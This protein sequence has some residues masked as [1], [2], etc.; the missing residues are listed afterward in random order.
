MKIS[1]HRKRTFRA[2]LRERGLRPGEGKQGRRQRGTALL[3][4]FDSTPF[5]CASWCLEPAEL[6]ERERERER[7]ML[8]FADPV[9][10]MLDDSIRG[11]KRMEENL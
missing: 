3:T 7:E 1:C 5:L 10:R 9:I 11:L 6:G 8:F 4:T 2:P